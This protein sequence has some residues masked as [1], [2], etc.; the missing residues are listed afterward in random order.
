MVRQKP[1]CWMRIWR[2]DEVGIPDYWSLITYPCSLIDYH[3][4]T[5]L[6][7][8]PFDLFPFQPTSTLFWFLINPCDYPNLSSFL[9]LYVCLGVVADVLV[10]W[11]SLTV[12]DPVVIGTTYGRVKAMIDDQVLG[13]CMHVL[14][15]IYP[16]NAHMFISHRLW[17][18][19][20]SSLILFL[21]LSLSLTIRWLMI[22]YYLIVSDIVEND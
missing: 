20:T 3:F 19:W 4:S 21:T 22:R 16:I 8:S 12:G 1:R 6:M 10:Q 2:K 11:G 15:S 14:I 13:R 7:M 17:H 18:C 5:F 9:P